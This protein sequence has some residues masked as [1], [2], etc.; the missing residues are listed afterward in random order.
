MLARVFH[1]HVYCTGEKWQCEHHGHHMLQCTYGCIRTP[2]CDKPIGIH[3]V[4]QFGF[5]NIASYCVNKLGDGEH[6]KIY[7]F[8]P[9]SV[10]NKEERT[11][12]QESS[13]FS[14]IKT[15]RHRHGNR[16]I[17][18]IETKQMPRHILPNTKTPSPI[19]ERQTSPACF[20]LPAGGS[21]T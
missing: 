19:E 12:R 9:T 14:C 8:A 3:K 4:L 21:G 17:V 20:C 1:Q 10:K 18:Q 5:Q 6:K 11:Y 7:T 15:R 16:C 2:L 13:R